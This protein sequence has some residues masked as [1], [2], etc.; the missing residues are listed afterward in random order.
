MLAF[1]NREEDEDDNEQ[2]ESIMSSEEIQQGGAYLSTFNDNKNFTEFKKQ[3]NSSESPYKVGVHKGDYAAFFNGITYNNAKYVVNTEHRS[4]LHTHAIIDMIT[5]ASKIDCIAYHSLK[6]YIFK[7]N[8]N[9]TYFSASS[10]G[11][12]SQGK[13]INTFLLKIVVLSDDNVSIKKLL[14]YNSVKKETESLNSF[15]NEARIQQ[16]IYKATRNKS[17]API[18]PAVMSFLCIKQSIE[19]H[20]KQNGSI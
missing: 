12:T 20:I 8:T 3:I 7:I 14:P 16:E 2:F 13:P 9:T 5:N 10:K 17:N 4:I 15:F 19:I 1:G 11:S 18:C 6:G